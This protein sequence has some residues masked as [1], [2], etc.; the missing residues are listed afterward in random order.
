V[1]RIM[2]FG[3]LSGQIG[4]IIGKLGNSRNA[5]PSQGSLKIGKGFKLQRES[6][7]NGATGQK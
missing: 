1:K 2:V 7:N 4:G 3:E 6:R 5:R